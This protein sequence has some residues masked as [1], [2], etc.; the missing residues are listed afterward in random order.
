MAERQSP[1]NGWS[2]ERNGLRLRELPLLAQI[3]VRSPAAPPAPAL[4]LGPDEWLIVGERAQE[5]DILD[6]LRHA[7]AVVKN[8]RNRHGETVYLPYEG[9]VVRAKIG[10]PKFFDLEG[11]RIN[12]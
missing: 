9:K 8:G 12:G 7:M 1:L 11:A 10:E 3:S 6:R 2:V 4:R 5:S